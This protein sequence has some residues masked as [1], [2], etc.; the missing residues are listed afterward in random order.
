MPNLQI[1]KNGLTINDLNDVF[2]FLSAQYKLIYGD[3]IILDADT[4]DGQLISIISKLNADA[5]AAL[6][7]IYNS[8]DPDNAVGVELNKLI[9]LSAMTRTPASKSTVSIDLTASTTIALDSNYTVVDELGQ[10]WIIQTAQSINAGVTAVIFEG[11]EFGSVQ[12]LATTI[13]ARGTILTQITNVNNPLAATVGRDEETDVELRQR[14]NRSL[15]KPTYSTVGGLL[16]RLLEVENVTD[17]LVYENATNIDDVVLPLVANTLWCI[18]E[19]GLDSDIFEAIAKEKTAGAG[20]KGSVVG[21][22]EE[23]FLRS[24]GT[25][26]IHTHPIKFDRPT[27]AEIYIKLDVTP[28]IALDVIDTDLIKTKLTEKIFTINEDLTITELYS[29]IYQAGDNFYANNVT[30]S[31]DNITYVSD[32]LLAGNTDKFLITTAKITITVVP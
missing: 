28:K 32:K 7:Q 26:R 15:E 30:A 31:T 6:L 10:N 4:P 14:R 16:A 12:A 18:V 9:K 2:E 27:I 29:Y 17:A 8:F 19:S 25:T 24:N 1:N 21:T 5:Q 23:S 3:D 11:A 20:L 22:Y 13:N